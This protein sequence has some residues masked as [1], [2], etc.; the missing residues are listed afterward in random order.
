MTF[1]TSMMSPKK[2]YGLL[3]WNFSKKN[4]ALLFGGSIINC[5]ETNAT[6]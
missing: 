2:E 6:V 4:S 1:V 3:K 5:A